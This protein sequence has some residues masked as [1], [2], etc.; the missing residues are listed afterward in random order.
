MAVS[1][2]LL[3]DY[4]PLSQLAFSHV[5]PNLKKFTHFFKREK[6]L[7]FD[8]SLIHQIDTVAL[9]AGMGV[10]YRLRG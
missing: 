7:N 9:V 8:Q 5:I 10:L 3:N 2:V 1:L 6:I 4:N